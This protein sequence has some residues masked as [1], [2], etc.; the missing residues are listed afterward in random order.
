MVVYVSPSEL[1]VLSVTREN[2]RDVLPLL[3]T[4][5]AADCRRRPLAPFDSI[6]QSSGE[7]CR[8]M[9]VGD[10]VGREWDGGKKHST[11][12]TKESDVLDI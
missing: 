11:M 8:V 7:W 9:R 6:R 3:V 4:L 12:G 1:S 2:R 10:G 5:T